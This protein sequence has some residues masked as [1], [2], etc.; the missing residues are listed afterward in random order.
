MSISHHPHQPR[1]QGFSLKKWV[2]TRLH[3]HLYILETII[4]NYMQIQAPMAD[5][6][7][8]LVSLV[9]G[10]GAL[11]L[12]REACLIFWLREWEGPFLE[13]GRLF[14]EI[15]AGNLIALMTWSAD[16]DKS[17]TKWR[18]CDTLPSQTVQDFDLLLHCSFFPCHPNI[19]LFFLLHGRLSH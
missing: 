7:I 12:E 9:R 2:G 10:G 11:I 16:H 4:V 13:R 8:S 1:P 6:L 5:C 19:L 15:S 14:E 18:H 17:K 3:P